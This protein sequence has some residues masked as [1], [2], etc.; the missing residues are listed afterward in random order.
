M[1]ART[2]VLAAA[3]AGG[4]VLGWLTSGSRL[5]T[6]LLAQDKP[7]PAGVGKLDRTVLPIP[8]PKREPI[9]ETDA[10]KAKAPPRFEVK[11][12]AKAPRRVDARALLALGR[13][14]L[15]GGRLKSE[16]YTAE[17][18]EAQLESIARE[19]VDRHEL[20]RIDRANNVLSVNPIFSWREEAFVQYYADQ[21]PPAFSQRSPLERA[22]LGLIRSSTLQSERDFL[23]Q[24]QF[25][26]EFHDFDWRLNDLTGR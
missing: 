14:A 16:A 5:T 6:G 4:V 22:V 13:G 1:R 15:D 18:V 19:A 8:E 3:L 2:L 12:P 23:E 17:R 10:R 9:T 20:V 26:M 11:A 21:A 25:S 7:T 24:N